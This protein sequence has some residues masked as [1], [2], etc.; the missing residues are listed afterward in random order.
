MNMGR[1]EKES[2]ME[3]E[4]R[5]KIK[6]FLSYPINVYFNTFEEAQDN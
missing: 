5:T 3:E 2:K 6:L 4:T 1:A